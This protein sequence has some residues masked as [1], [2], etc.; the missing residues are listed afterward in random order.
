VVQYS[1]RII[2]GKKPYSG[3]GQFKFAL[4]DLA[5]QRVWSNDDNEPPF[6]AGAPAL[7]VL[8]EVSGGTYQVRLGDPA[9][10]MKPLNPAVTQSWA[11]LKL[12]TW[13]NDGTSGWTD[14][15][16]APLAASPSNPPPASA[17]GEEEFR[18]TVL[19]ELGR[20]RT[21]IGAMRKELHA[22]TRP[23]EAAPQAPPPPA[24]VQ[25][26]LLDSNRYSL[27]AADAPVVLVEFTDFECGFCKR[28]F[29]QTFPALKAKFIDTGKLR[30]VSRNLPVQRHPQAGPAATALLGAAAQDPG[31]YWAMRTWLFKDNRELSEASYEKYAREAGLDVPRF[32][33]DFTNQLYA[34]DL[35]ADMAA[36][37]SVGIT[38]TPTFVI[39][40]SDGKTI[41]GELIQ[42]AKPVAVFEGLIETLLSLETSAHPAAASSPV[43]PGKAK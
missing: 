29:D 17:P 2:G 12:Q 28:F 37:A 21:E 25:V 41:R 14:A 43:T 35:K 19:A 1:G 9:A 23:S 10:G 31:Q 16:I 40:R 5:G 22:G 7:S 24:P 13:F 38:G 6:E 3:Q 34:A 36:A 15:G 33:A 18:Q 42:G 8:V 11:A 30:F 4:N 32:M 20:L 26:S 39:G 27:G